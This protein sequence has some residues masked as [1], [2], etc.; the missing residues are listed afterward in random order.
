MAEILSFDTGIKEYDINGVATVRFNPTDAN[1]TDRLYKSFNDLKD[2]Q[3]EFEQRVADIGDDGEE[4]FRYAHERDVEMREI[5]DTVFDCP[6][7]ADKLF[8]NMNCYA[9]ADDGTP[10]WIGLFMSVVNVVDIAMRKSRK[11]ND[12]RLREYDEKHAELLKKYREAT[13][14]K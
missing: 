13:T 2:R 3:D 1:F 4:M 7:L 6:G 8:E 11:A 9:L 12:P 5:I 14:K 10:V